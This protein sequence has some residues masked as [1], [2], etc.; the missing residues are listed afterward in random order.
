MYNDGVI[1]ETLRVW[2]DGSVEV[3]VAT[4]RKIDL[5]K[6]PF[7]ISL[8]NGLDTKAF[9]ILFS[10]CIALRNGSGRWFHVTITVHLELRKHG[11]MVSLSHAVGDICRQQARLTGT[12]EGV[13]INIEEGGILAACATGKQKVVI[14]LGLGAGPRPVHDL[15]MVRVDM[16][17]GGRGAVVVDVEP[18]DAEP[19]VERDPRR[20]EVGVVLDLGH[21]AE[22]VA[23]AVRAGRVEQ[24]RVPA[25]VRA[26][27]GDAGVGERGV[28][29]GDI[30]A[31]N[32][33]GDAVDPVGVAD[34]GAQGV[35]PG[36]KDGERGAD[37]RERRDKAAHGLGEG[38]VH[39]VQ[40]G[41]HGAADARE[42][43]AERAGVGARGVDGEDE[44]VVAVAV[45][46]RGED[47]GRAP[48]GRVREGR[49]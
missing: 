25:D 7:K 37:G 45:G 31:Q 11:L 41:A 30:A 13:L 16:T 23:R 39:A 10:S 40:G 6:E 12:D 28:E 14:R 5:V 24:A 36:E 20:E 22:L 46:V 32:R 2:D 33:E 49:G 19:A 43:A 18:V 21:D 27:R 47:G 17:E 3:G 1:V 29:R 34:G 38:A 15:G 48:V 8:Q 4:L 35:V 42:V 9:L 44:A 26:D